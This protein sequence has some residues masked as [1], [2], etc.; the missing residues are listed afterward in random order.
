M[1][2]L[3]QSM[4][5]SLEA[6]LDAGFS[7]RSEPLADEVEPVQA[8][9]SSVERLFLHGFEGR[10]GSPPRYSLFLVMAFLLGAEAVDPGSAGEHDLSLADAKRR[11]VTDPDADTLAFKSEDGA[12]T[13]SVRGKYEDVHKLFYTTLGRTDAP[14]G[15]QQATNNWQ[16]FEEQLRGA[17]SLSSAGRFAAFRYLLEFGLA[18]FPLNRFFRQESRVRLFEKIVSAYDRTAPRGTTERAG[19]AMQAIVYGFIAADR[20]HLDIAADKVGGGSRR[21]R[22]I[23]D[24]DCYRGLVPELTVEVKDLVIDESNYRGPRGLGQFMTNVEQSG[25]FALAVV[26]DVRDGHEDAI[27]AGLAAAGIRLL[28][29][30]DLASIVATWDW[31]KQDT[32]AQATLHYLSH[33]EQKDS[34]TSRLITFLREHDPEHESLRQEQPDEQSAANDSNE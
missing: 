7:A 11:F 31:A 27:S 2:D 4:T 3:D 28:T 12:L 33:V 6:F 22:R 9:V 20:R 18:Q 8:L 14:Y 17:F 5:A 29:L 16:R 21:Q 24:I 23:G 34:A 26:A 1:D 19:T 25:I 30:S 10:R 15:P 32:A 13:A